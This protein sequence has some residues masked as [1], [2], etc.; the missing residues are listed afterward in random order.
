VV[1]GL[2]PGVVTGGV[3]GVVFSLM[4]KP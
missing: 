3:G 4:R 2:V 1:A